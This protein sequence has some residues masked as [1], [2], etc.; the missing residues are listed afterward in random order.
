MYLKIWDAT[1]TLDNS[2]P[3]IPRPLFGHWIPREWHLALPD[4]RGPLLDPQCP[5]KATFLTIFFYFLISTSLLRNRVIWN[6]NWLS[7]QHPRMIPIKV[8]LVFCEPG[9]FTLW[10]RSVRDQGCICCCAQE[11]LWLTF[12]I[13]LVDFRLIGSGIF[14]NSWSK[15]LL[16]K[17]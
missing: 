9:S 17:F 14:F 2:T 7:L 13:T 1:G 12:G 6:I 11:M 4:T 5:W 3:Q 15:G 16:V 10:A 8:V